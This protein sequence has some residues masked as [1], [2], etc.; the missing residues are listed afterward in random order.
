MLVKTASPS[1]IT[2]HLISFSSNN[3]YLIH[4]EMVSTKRLFANRLV[5]TANSFG[6]KSRVCLLDC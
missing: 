1:K 4:G 6:T 3:L 2:I 5:N